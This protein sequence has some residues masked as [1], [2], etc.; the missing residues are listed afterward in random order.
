MTLKPK[1]NNSRI[2]PVRAR[3]RLLSICFG[4]FCSLQALGQH[5]SQGFP[6]SIAKTIPKVALGKPLAS[7][8]LLQKVPVD[9][10]LPSRRRDELSHL[11]SAVQY[12]LSA[13]AQIQTAG[14]SSDTQY[15]DQA[16]VD[17]R[18][19]AELAFQ[20]GRAEAAFESVYETG[21]PGQDAFGHEEGSLR[22]GIAWVIGQVT[23]LT[24]QRAALQKQ[25]SE[26]KRDQQKLLKE[27]ID[28]IDDAINLDGEMS[29]A[30]AKIQ[31]NSNLLG[32]PGMAGDIDRLQRTTPE[33]IDGKA[34]PF[35]PALE[36]LSG[37]ASAG[38]T[39]QVSSLFQLHGARSAIDDLIDQTKVIEQ[40]ATSLEDPLTAIVQKSMNVAPSNLQEAKGAGQGFEFGPAFTK[41]SFAA[42][43]ATLKAL[44]ATAVP[45]SQEIVTLA[46]ARANLLAWRTAVNLEYRGVVRSL[47]LR[48]VGIAV[49]LGVLLILGEVWKR[50]TVRWVHDVR[51]RRQL[52]G[53][54]R[55]VIGCL[56]ALVLFF[57][58]V[59]QFHSVATVAGFIVAG[60]AV[61]LQT[62]LLSV[63]AYFFII[64]RYGV[65][66]GD[67]MTITGVTGDVIEVDLLRF[68][69]LELAGDGD[70]LAPTGRVAVFNNA[71]LFQAGI[72]V[73]KQMPGIEYTWHEMTL[74]LHPTCPREEVSKT[75]LA[76]VSAIYEKYRESVEQQHKDVM[77]WADI[78]AGAPKVES[79]LQ[80]AGGG[81][82][83]LVRF[84]VK[85]D[86]A[87][88]VDAQV[89]Q[90]M[91]HLMVEDVT[92]KA[93]VA[94]DP[95]IKA[96]VQA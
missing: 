65:Q 85:L 30:L 3:I 68:Y 94:A 14:S 31:T 23:K 40:E 12:Y 46:Q 82:Q 18:Q 70:E 25:I 44:S 49:V 73:Y 41:E 76:A 51:R 71:V 91:A 11:N 34:T 13:I 93:A 28:Q 24:A 33:L 1:G 21:T 84:P 2:Q 17:G 88:Q 36:S 39:S 16:I 27:Q 5:P 56:C 61:G 48:F 22:T 67:R 52:M 87:T 78:R 66:V 81:L 64:G 86:N 55:I 7:P 35:A 42:T 38:L 58:C 4:V 79:R 74:S 32:H 59:T 10:D 60:L 89:T 29:D 96:T 53:P 77:G 72:P 83:L 63:A 37:V 45:L 8:V 69:L 95:T 57:G 75:I 50:L 9:L 26:A 90:A 43:S 20:S 6:A 80:F 54:R 92:V 62:I 47:V 19:V 15:R